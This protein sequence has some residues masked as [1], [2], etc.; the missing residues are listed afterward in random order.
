M[1]MATEKQVQISARMYDARTTLRSLWGAE[2]LA[3]LKPM[4]DIVSAVAAGR[5]ISTLQASIDMGKELKE[6][7]KLP[8]AML[9]LLMAAAVE[10]T[11]PTEGK[12]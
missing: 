9:W 7:G 3:K 4:M 2:Y 8:T 6:A 11:E 10:L 5:R 1:S 12:P